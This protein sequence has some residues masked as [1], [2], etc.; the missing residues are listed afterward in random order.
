MRRSHRPDT[1]RPRPTLALATGCLVLG[2]AGQALAA[3]GT[4]LRPSLVVQDATERYVVA[5]ETGAVVLNL[6]DDKGRRGRAARAGTSPGC[7][8]AAACSH[9]CP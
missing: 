5:G 8:P 6:P 9:S 1:L 4:L 2:L 3:P 7:G